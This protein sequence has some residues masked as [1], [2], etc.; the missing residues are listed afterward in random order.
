MRGFDGDRSA[1]AG[2]YGCSYLL[3]QRICWLRLAGGDVVATQVEHLGGDFYAE[4]VPL[5]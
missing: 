4:G 2:V 1:R 3:P 5:A